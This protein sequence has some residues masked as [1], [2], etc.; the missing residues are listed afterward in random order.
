MLNF[1]VDFL[2]VTIYTQV[3]SLITTKDS[4]DPEKWPSKVGTTQGRSRT[5]Q[6]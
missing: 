5:S 2:V 1:A 4:Q 6:A 3:F